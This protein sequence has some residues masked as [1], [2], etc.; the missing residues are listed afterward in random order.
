MSI[1]SIVFSATIT[2]SLTP[3]ID[4]RY[5]IGVMVISEGC[6]AVVACGYRQVL[7]TTR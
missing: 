3:Y 7:V 5:G 4:Y 6:I 2:H 1:P